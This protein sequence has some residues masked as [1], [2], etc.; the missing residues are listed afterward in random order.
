[1]RSKQPR[2]QA[3]SRHPSDSN[4]RIDRRHHILNRRGRQGT[5]LRSKR[6]RLLS[7]QGIP[8]AKYERRGGGGEGRFPSF[9]P[10]PSPLFY[11]RHFSRGRSWLRNRTGTIA[12]PA[13]KAQ[14]GCSNKAKNNGPFQSSKTSHFQN[15]ASAKSF[16]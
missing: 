14:G 7:E 4:S 10:H 15:E 11:S 5:R 13:V 6:F 2:T 12:T 8:R 16:L 1:M 9:L 3:S